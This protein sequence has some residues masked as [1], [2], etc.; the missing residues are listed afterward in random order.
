M[1]STTTTGGAR[2]SAAQAELSR[3]A[4]TPAQR[5]QHLL[6][7]NP[8]LSPLV[9][10]I[11]TIIVFSIV[12]P[13]FMQ[14]NSISLLVQQTAVVA[15][16]ALGQT[17]VILTAGIDL[18]CGAI[19]VLS[20]MIMASLSAKNGLPG[21]LALAIG[22]AAGLLAGYINGLLVTRLN[23]PPFIV[24]LGTL[25]IFTAIALLYS[26]AESIQDNRLPD[27]LNWT[28]E[29][30]LDS[31][32]PGHER[33]SPRHHHVRRGRL[34]AEPDGMGTAPVRGG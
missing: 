33:G 16:L 22:V 7:G 13:R 17:L 1:S 29:Q 14:A 25:S 2:Q 31:G 21:I 20:M 4:Q 11:V 32:V 27:I 8:W 3:R 5:I 23:L 9:L 26:G 6:H 19:C 34:R 10:L 30:L 12:N 15:A 18:S 24:T 28:G